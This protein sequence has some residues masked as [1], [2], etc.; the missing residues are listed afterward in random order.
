MVS[1][2]LLTVCSASILRRSMSQANFFD[3]SMHFEPVSYD[4][5]DVHKHHLRRKR[6][7]A[8]EVSVKFRGLD[9][10]FHLRLKPDA[11]MFHKDLVVETTEQ[12]IVE[13]EL[14]HIYSGY[15]DGDIGSFVYGGLHDGEFE[16]GIITSNGS[17]YLESARKYFNFETPF[18]SVLY[19]SRDVVYPHPTKTKTGSWCGLNSKSRSWMKQVYS[20]IVPTP[21]PHKDER[22]NSWIGRRLQN[23]GSE[24][25][26][27]REYKQVKEKSFNDSTSGRAASAGRRVCNL[28]YNIDH[29]LYG[30]YSE[31]SKDDK[32]TRAR[33]SA[34]ISAH[35]QKAN[36]IYRTT[37]FHGIEDISFI[38]QR[39]HINDSSNCIGEK[40]ATNPFCTSL[41]E[42]TDFLYAQSLR[43]HDEFCLSYAWTYR[44]FPDGVLGLAWIALSP[45][46]DPLDATGGICQKYKESVKQGTRK[47]YKL[48][49]NTGIVSFINFNDFVPQQISELTQA[50][51]I[52][53]NFGSPHD[54]GEVC[55]P[56]QAGGGNYI[57]YPCA[58]KGDLKNN[59]KFSPCSINFMSGVLGPILSGESYRENCFQEYS[60]PLCGNDITE[61][62]EQCDCGMDASECT[63]VC[64]YARHND[65]KKQGCTLK[66]NKIC[67]P[68]A[69][70]CCSKDCRFQPRGTHCE[71]EEDCTH[72]AVCSG[73]SSLCP[74]PAKKADGTL[75]NSNTQICKDGRCRGSVCEKYGLVGCTLPSAQYDI[76]QQ[77]LVACKE[78]GTENS[79]CYPACHFPTMK[80]LCG[81]QMRP[82]APCLELKGFCDV[83]S[84]CRR[85][86]AE[87]P[88]VT[89]QK[90]LIGAT[91]GKLEA[92][93]QAHTVASI[94]ILIAIIGTVSF[95]IS[96]CA[97]N[98]PSSNPKR[99]HQAWLKKFRRQM[100]KSLGQSSEETATNMGMGGDGEVTS[101]ELLKDASEMTTQRQ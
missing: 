77:C 53:H 39:I 43:N 41:M 78:N 56:G 82:G 30:K 9:R 11:S 76:N 47:V 75:C 97:V 6:S 84:K 70:A 91:I 55:A 83:F 44:D 36:Q 24:K 59:D 46:N 86:N 54:E 87:G 85:I 4:T 67:S 33:L 28:E 12:G 57:M 22:R 32:A 25:E 8:D 66:P 65:A 26:R 17:F 23:M 10:Y 1:F 38:V 63:D 13:P 64:C 74:K 7:P 52:G 90:I 79:Y 48:S 101:P 3:I 34:S 100:R 51:E 42:V 15:V 96:L 29:L 99:K 61:G 94:F 49:L 45:A 81:L 37:D 92:F 16:G 27:R 93:I 60:G 71:M 68:T 89:L 62:A 19:D 21:R 18:H 73:R 95:L 50:H 72:I 98:T 40:A 31:G 69:G 2:A 88:L 80:K 58:T 5:A 14:D 20:N 35:I